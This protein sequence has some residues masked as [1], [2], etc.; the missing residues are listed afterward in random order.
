MTE[1]LIVLYGALPYLL[2][3]SLVTIAVVAGAMFL[4]LVLGIHLAVGQ[5]YGGRWL[6]RVIGLYVWFFRGVPLLVLLFLFYF[7]LCSLLQ[8]NLS[9]FTVSVIVLGLIS[10]AYQSQIFRG[11]IMSLPQG[12]FK[13]AR[14]L[15]MSDGK[16]IA[17]IIMPQALRLSIPGWS[18][19]YSIVLKDSAV[20]YALGV[21]E[22]MARAH[23]VA[24]RTYEHLPM[25]FAAGF[26][27]MILTYLGTKGLRML[28]EKVRIPG[29]S[30]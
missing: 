21:M 12:Q 30:A 8:I 3:G 23:F 13:A 6:R 1:S 7:G 10:S 29:Y 20:A 16:A 25:Y 19:E 22:M 2:R 17:L 15:G 14:A 9:A 27:F 24:S 4:G 28:E 5:V 18:N 26:L 11:A